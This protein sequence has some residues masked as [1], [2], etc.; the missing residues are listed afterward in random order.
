MLIDVTSFY[1]SC[2][3]TVV[4]VSERMKGPEP[5][6]TIRYPDTT[7]YSQV[8]HDELLSSI[9]HIIDMS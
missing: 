8:Q 6:L 1:L 2:I 7:T 9:L 3:R 5:Q 4:V